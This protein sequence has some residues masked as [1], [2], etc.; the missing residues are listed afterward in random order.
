MITKN[1]SI[2]FYLASEFTDSIKNLENEHRILK[3]QLKGK[4]VEPD[5]FIW[6]WWWTWLN[7]CYWEGQVFLAQVWCQPMSVQVHSNPS[8]DQIIHMSDTSCGKKLENTYNH[9]D[10]KIC[11]RVYR[12]QISKFST[13]PKYE[14]FD[15]FS[16]RILYHKSLGLCMRYHY[17]SQTTKSTGFH[18]W[19]LW[20]NISAHLKKSQYLQIK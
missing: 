15:F 16:F 8:N 14:I 6:P 2:I 11:W 19:R 7:A 3:Q 9:F 20:I 4:S 17:E 18:L 12:N 10:F 13:I 5:A 1:R